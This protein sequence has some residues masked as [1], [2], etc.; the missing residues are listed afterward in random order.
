MDKPKKEMI[1]KGY[2]YKDSN[3]AECIISRINDSLPHFVPSYKTSVKSIL[4]VFNILKK[5][6]P[7]VIEEQCWILNN[8][9][10]ANKLYFESKV[11]NTSYK[12]ELEVYLKFLQKEQEE[13]E[14]F[15]KENLTMHD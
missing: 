15:L 2:I 5:T 6:Y 12:K 10:D 3:A 1:I 11:G 14:E 9:D 8:P 4:Q 7:D 13:V